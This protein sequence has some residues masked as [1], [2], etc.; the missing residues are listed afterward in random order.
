ME[1]RFF[2]EEWKVAWVFP[3]SRFVCEM[4]VPDTGTFGMIFSTATTRLKEWYDRH[5]SKAVAF[6]LRLSANSR[7]LEKAQES[8]QALYEDKVA[9]AFVKKLKIT[10]VFQDITTGQV[11]YYDCMKP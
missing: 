6:E 10:I 5:P 1:T 2:Q 8:I 4:L 11:E 7:V 3:R 9:Y